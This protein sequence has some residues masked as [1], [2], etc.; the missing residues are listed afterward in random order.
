MCITPWKAITSLVE[1]TD[2]HPE[3]LIFHATDERSRNGLFGLIPAQVF[4]F[5][6]VV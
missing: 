2:Q 3:I 5:L 4:H 6:I 1:T